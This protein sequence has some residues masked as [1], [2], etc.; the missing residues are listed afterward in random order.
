[1]PNRTPPLASNSCSSALLMWMSFSGM[2]PF[3]S[4]IRYVLNNLRRLEWTTPLITGAGL[5]I[6]NMCCIKL[7][8]FGFGANSCSL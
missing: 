4:F 2:T 8:I 6:T 7:R 3:F 1:M 5:V